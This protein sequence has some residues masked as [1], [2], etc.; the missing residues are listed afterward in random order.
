[1]RELVGHY[2]VVMV[3]PDGGRIVAEAMQVLI[4]VGDRQDIPPLPAVVPEERYIRVGKLVGEVGHTFSVGQVGG[5]AGDGG[6]HLVANVHLGEVPTYA[7]PVREVVADGQVQP[8]G[9]YLP[10]VDVG[11]RLLSPAEVGDVA[12]DIVPGV[13]VDQAAFEVERV[14]SEGAVVADVQ[15]EIIA[16]LRTNA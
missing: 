8:L 5:T 11:S 13:A 12:L 9:L 3:R 15:V 16:V 10:I 4:V 7:Q 6:F 14:L 1:M 2:I